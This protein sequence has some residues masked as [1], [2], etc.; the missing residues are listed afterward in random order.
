MMF[1]NVRAWLLRSWRRN[2]P[3]CSGCGTRVM[4]D[5]VTSAECL[6]FFSVEHGL[7][8]RGGSAWEVR[9]AG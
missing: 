4:S 5:P 3:M 2:H 8:L 1:R 7:P 9:K 6:C